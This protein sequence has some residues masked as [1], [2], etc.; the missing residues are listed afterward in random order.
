[1]VVLAREL[2]NASNG[3][4]WRGDRQGLFGFSY[5]L[6]IPEIPYSYALSLPI[7]IPLNVTVNELGTNTFGYAVPLPFTTWDRQGACGAGFC[8]WTDWF[9]PVLA[10]TLD[11]AGSVGPLIV[12]DRTTIGDDFAADFSQSG[13][14]ILGPF[15]FLD[16]TWRQNPGYFNSSTAPSSGFFNSGAG[17]NSGIDNDGSS[18]SGIGNTGADISGFF[19][20]LLILTS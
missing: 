14:G 9:A 15:D 12:L 1:M 10:Y 13:S 8:T 6:V 17:G 5:A 16:V 2:Q 11:L 20:T 3:L 7:D 18:N 19:N 4:L